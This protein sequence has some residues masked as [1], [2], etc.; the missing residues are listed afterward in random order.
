MKDY[1]TTRR[2]L[3]ICEV[4]GRTELLTA[5]EAFHN[6]WDYPPRMGAFG[7]VS[8]RTCPDCP[9]T[10]TVWAELMLKE[11]KPED[12]NQR[13]SEALYRIL[14]EPLNLIGREDMGNRAV[15]TTRKNLETRGIGVYLHWNGGRDSVEAFLEYCRLRRFRPPDEDCLGWAR[16]VQVIANYLQGGLSIG[17]ETVDHLNTDNGDNGVY[18]IEGWIITGR[19]YF[20]G[21]E[22]DNHD[23]DDLLME[24]DLAQPEKD[25]LGFEFLR[26][27]EDRPA[28]EIRIGDQ[29][30]IPVCSEDTL[31]IETVNGIRDD[32]VPY[33]ERYGRTF[34]LME[35]SYRVVKIN[36]PQ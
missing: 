26:L 30:W 27:S 1:F 28:C 22:Q 33:I 20:N 35:P 3:H 15:I 19:E 9:A 29:V 34:Y 6:G 12:L 17:V 5:E 25:R 24:I 36:K 23:R 21:A 18:I 4:C 32:G 14:E 10:E 13:Q 31:Q 7:V 8:P 2:F 11:K 16:L